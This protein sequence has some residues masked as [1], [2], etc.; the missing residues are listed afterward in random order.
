MTD[1]YF[2]SET[3]KPVM[4]FT[5]KFEFE[6]VFSDENMTD[7]VLATTYRILYT[8]CE[9]AFLI[10]ENQKK[11]IGVFQK[12]NEKLVSTITILEE[13]VTLLNSKIENMT[14]YVHMLNNGSNML[15][16]IFQVGK[17]SI[18]MKGIG[19]ESNLTRKLKFPLRSL[20]FLR[21]RLSFRC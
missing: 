6:S 13:E 16:G 10:V 17:M 20:F 18:N 9:E 1:S 12:E 11:T 19:F 3:T 4:A 7:E 2:D 14:K 21:R 8:K 15:D 5:I